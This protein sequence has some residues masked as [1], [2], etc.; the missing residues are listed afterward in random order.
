MTRKLLAAF[1]TACL[2]VLFGCIKPKIS[3]F[4]DRTDPLEEYTL[5]GKGDEKILLIPVKGFISDSSKGVLS[6][7][8]GTVQE[9]VS[10]LNKAEQDKKIKAVLLKI[11]SSGGSVTASDVL[12]H[13]LTRYKECSGAKLVAVM[14]TVAASGGYYIALPADYIMAHPTTVT[15]SI[16]VVFLRPNLTGL[17]G[18][19]G[20][21]VEVDK[22]GR[23]KDMGSPFR[24]ATP[25]EQQMMQK[26]ID[27]MAGRFVS[28]TASR[29]HLSEEAREQ[30]ASARIYSANDALRLGLVDRIGYLDDA[31]RE[32]ARM[33]GLPDDA[34]VVVYR[35]AEYHDDNLYNVSAAKQATPEINLIDPAITEMLPPLQGGFY[36]MWLPGGID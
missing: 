33:S 15:G 2:F 22:S 24:K 1:L 17:M 27:D 14:M 7:R 10:Q 20:V 12:Y 9:V 23:N 34:K 8:P 16:G 11:D 36:Y 26:L 19:I 13:E 28:L 29:R 31:I 5:Q 32:A 35:R 3:V 18:K 25:E 30:V 21:D 6:R 4:P